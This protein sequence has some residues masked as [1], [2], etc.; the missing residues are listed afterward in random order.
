MPTCP[1]CNDE[2]PKL[3]SVKVGGKSCTVCA[4]CADRLREKGEV[5]TNKPNRK[6]VSVQPTVQLQ[7][8]PTV[9][10]QDPFSR[11]EFMLWAASYLARELGFPPPNIAPGTGDTSYIFAKDLYIGVVANVQATTSFPGPCVRVHLSTTA[12]HRISRW[13]SGW[14]PRG[15]APTGVSVRIRLGDGG[16]VTY[17]E[18]LIPNYAKNYG[19]VVSNAKRCIDLFLATKK[20]GE[21]V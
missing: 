1:G 19:A 5:T 16:K 8:Q 7:V 2:V 6:V 3:V 13:K 4:N 10:L 18:Y 20:T 15:T 17:L 14:R 11:D 21:I 12:G 9:Q